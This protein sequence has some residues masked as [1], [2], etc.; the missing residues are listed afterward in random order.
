LLIH[1]ANSETNE[2]ANKVLKEVRKVIN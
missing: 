2:S 1:H